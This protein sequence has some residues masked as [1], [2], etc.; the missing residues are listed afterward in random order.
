MTRTPIVFFF[1]GVSSEHEVSCLT[2][3]GVLSALDE[4]RFEAYGV[5]IDRQGCWHRY[6]AA[7]I[8][9]LKVNDGAFPS[10]DASGRAALLY[11]G[12]NGEVTLATIDGDTLRDKVRV[13]VA[14]PLLHG[15]FGEDGTIQGYFEMLGLRYVGAGVAASALGIDKHLSKLA[16]EAA[17]LQV[18][19][20]IWFTAR[21]WAN[22]AAS[23][24]ARASALGYPLYVKPARGG[25]SVGITRVTRED[26][27]EAAVAVALEHDPKVVI[28]AGFVNAR[29]VE[30]GV[31][32]G[33]HGGPVRVTRPAEI[34]MHVK[35]G[36]YDFEA[37]YVSDS[38]AELQVPADLSAEIEARVCEAAAAAFTA[39]GGEGLS[40]VDS[41]VLPDGTVALNEANTLPGFTQ[42]SMF[43]RTWMET[44][45]SYSEIISDLIDQALE[46]PLGLR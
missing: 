14:F 32:G 2:A 9:A 24:S 45:L 15:P 12:T 19:P 25:S 46:R 16:F 34:V 36:F 11:R 23:L 42:I 5:G 8:R 38:Q 10:V 1:G 29:E 30:C 37:K 22:D 4:T 40:R 43:P 28:E 6:T 33:R 20:Y 26:A 35:D 18:A 7:E 44:G 3:A 41:F 21:D 17:G 13:E 27:L 31:M 39:L